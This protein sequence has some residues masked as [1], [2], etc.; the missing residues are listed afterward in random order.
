M[1]GE[2]SDQLKDNC[3]VEFELNDINNNGYMGMDEVIKFVAK[4]KSLG[5]DEYRS[6]QINCQMCI[7]DLTLYYL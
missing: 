3:T 2:E 1:A 4:T 5:L 7:D 6:N